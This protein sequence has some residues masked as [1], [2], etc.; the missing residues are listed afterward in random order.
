M[1]WSRLR[2]SKT[3]DQALRRHSTIDDSQLERHSE[4]PTLNDDER[5]GR[6]A[7]CPTENLK[8]PLD[9]LANTADIGRLSTPTVQERN[10]RQRFSMLKFRHASDSQLSKTAKEHALARAPPVPASKC[11]PQFNIGLGTQVSNADDFITSQHPRL[12]L[13]CL[14]WIPST[15][16]RRRSRHSHYHAAKRTRT[17]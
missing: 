17:Y 2:V 16:P 14:L 7:E 6:D 15:R 1:P 5:L 12:S 4:N 13:L 10:P 8:A 11:L 9:A 3:S